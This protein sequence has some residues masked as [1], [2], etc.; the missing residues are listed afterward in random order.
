MFCT[1]CG[2]PKEEAGKCPNCDV[3]VAQ[4]ASPVEETVFFGDD[5]SGRK[6]GRGK[7]RLLVIA[8]ILVPILGVGGY[9]A[10]DLNNK[11]QAKSYAGQGCDLIQADWTS[12]S[13]D[14]A[15]KKFK[16]AAGI[17]PKYKPLVNNVRKWQS[18]DLQRLTAEI[19]M[20][21]IRLD[22]LNG[23]YWYLS[24]SE[25]YTKYTLPQVLKKMSAQGELDAQKAE[26]QKACSALG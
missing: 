17:D 3:E 20:I 13:G 22:V 12:T 21:Q 6:R 24:A 18:A 1:T 5:G 8:A 7:K 25:I 26:I 16:L 19:E 23:D 11:A 4:G 2:T 14:A 15:T 9:F 10:N